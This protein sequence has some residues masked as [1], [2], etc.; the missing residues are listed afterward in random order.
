MQKQVKRK[1]KL[2]FEN[3]VSKNYKNSYNNIKT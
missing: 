2:K 3:H 1:A